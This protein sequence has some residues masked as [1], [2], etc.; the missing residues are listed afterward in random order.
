MSAVGRVYDSGMAT[1]VCAAC[2]RRVPSYV[3]VCHC[4]AGRPRP[5]SV[6]AAE[7]PEALPLG[8]P[9]RVDPRQVP[10][11]V[12]LAIGVMGVALLVGAVSLWF[13]PRRPEPVVPLLGYIDRVPQAARASP[14]P[15]ATKPQAR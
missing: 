7:Q 9:L 4:G 11:Q 5:G 10:W 14:S 12:W 2:R 3:E 13:L 6:T 15:P 8:A 1:W